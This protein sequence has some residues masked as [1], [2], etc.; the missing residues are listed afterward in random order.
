MNI[1]N[2]FPFRGN[3]K[4]EPAPVD[5]K[6]VTPI[7][8]QEQIL[9][10]SGD[11]LNFALGY[12]GGLTG[13]E[14]MS[15]ADAMKFYRQS[16]SVATAVDIIAQEVERISPVVEL[17]DGTLTDD[18]DILKFLG[19][20]NDWNETL[21]FFM[22][23]LSRALSLTGDNY[24]YASGIITNPPLEIYAI[25]PQNV[26][27]E[28]GNIDQ[29]PTAYTIYNG[30]GRGSYSRRRDKTGFRFYDGNLKELWHTQG[31]SSTFSNLS[32][33]S[34]LTAIALDIYSQIKGR[35]HNTKLLDNGA[36]PSLLVAFKD[37]MTQDQHNERRQLINEQLA[38][39]DNAGKIGVISSSDMDMKELGITNKDMDY[40]ELERI[41]EHAV[42]KRYRIPLP[43]I[44]TDALTDNNMAHAVYQLYDFAVLPQVE[45]IFSSLTMFLMPRYGLNPEEYKI[46]YN[47]DDI[48]A[49]KQRRIDILKKRKDLN[50]ET[51]N[52]LREGLPNRDDIDGGDSI[53]VSSTMIPISEASIAEKPETNTP[54]EEAQN[55]ID[56][57]D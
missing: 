3:K 24:V 6:S 13:Y 10:Q 4:T 51:T 57:D 47:P 17:P 32:G 22:G 33:D 40:K 46:T 54:E 38:G 25:K 20:P 56:R 53:L 2:W 28:A 36:R 50:I 39:S 16:S 42:Y 44:S 45:N 35:I 31:Y 5:K 30:D 26:N 41:S 55:L 43:L 15:N 19:N 29:R 1:K 8:G 27:T 21:S 12:G 37:T 18:H 9:L 14:S 11:F 52:E 48:E 7:G 49:L 23:S 34:N